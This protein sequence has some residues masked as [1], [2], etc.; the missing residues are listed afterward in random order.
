MKHTNANATGDFWAVHD[1]KSKAASYSAFQKAYKHRRSVT[2]H[3]KEPFRI[4]SAPVLVLKDMVAPGNSSKTVE[5]KIDMTFTAD[6]LKQYDTLNKTPELFKG[7]KSKER[8]AQLLELLAL[9]LR[10]LL[11]CDE[12][13]K[14]PKQLL[15]G[16]E[17]EAGDQSVLARGGD[18]NDDS[19][20]EGTDPKAPSSPAKKTQT[21]SDCRFW[22]PYA[23]EAVAWNDLGFSDDGASER[24]DFMP[25]CAFFFYIDILP[26]KFPDVNN[27]LHA[28]WQTK[29]KKP[30][31][32][33]ALDEPP[34]NF[35]EQAQM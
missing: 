22:Q 28:A 7:C 15:A 16:T 12:A 18:G 33:E 20:Q 25:A 11:A 3:L 6:D 4:P 31:S 17:E 13:A 24:E 1:V 10:F 27:A 30:M 19:E 14:H 35:D 21:V 2:G 34:L 23:P 32:A 26:R 8:Y 9:D 5:L 29:Y